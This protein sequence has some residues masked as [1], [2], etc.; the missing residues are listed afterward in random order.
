MKFSE[1]HFT[2]NC[3]RRFA[4]AEDLHEVGAE[5]LSHEQKKHRVTISCK[6]LKRLKIDSN[7]LDRMITSD[8]FWIFE[9][10][11]ET[12]RQSVTQALL[13]N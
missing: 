2:F 6:L 4:N 10:D 8:E 9:Y 11:P 13:L 1:I 12:K 3:D 7:L 5:D